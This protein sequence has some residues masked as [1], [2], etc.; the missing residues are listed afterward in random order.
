MDKGGGM[1]GVKEQQNTKLNMILN[2]KKTHMN[3][4]QQ[5]TL[6]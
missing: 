2:H 5:I 3:F 4:T 6:V 1:G